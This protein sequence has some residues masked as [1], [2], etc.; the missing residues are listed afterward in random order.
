MPLCMMV[1]GRTLQVFCTGANTP[2]VWRTRRKIIT[3]VLC[4]TFLSHSFKFSFG[5]QF[6]L[7]VL[8]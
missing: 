3:T 5:I 6:F 8:G 2:F 4:C 1:M 7:L